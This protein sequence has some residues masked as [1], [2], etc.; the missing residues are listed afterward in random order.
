MSGSSLAQTVNPGLKLAWAGPE[1]GLTLGVEVTYFD[2]NGFFYGF[3]GGYDY[4][5]G[6][7]RHKI[8][9]GPY[10]GVNIERTAPG[11]DLTG[12]LI[13]ER[14]KF[15]LGA[16]LT[17]F[18]GVLVIP[19]YTYTVRLND[20]PINEVGVFIKFNTTVPR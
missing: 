18:F 4:C 5:V 17:A 2:K 14:G 9:V 7:A 6:K 10:G 12:V 19:H 11:I 8:R 13:L 20:Q 16:S 3:V 1:D 15:D